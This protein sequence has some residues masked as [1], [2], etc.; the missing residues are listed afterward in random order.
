MSIRPESFLQIGLLRAWWDQN[1]NGIHNQ[2]NIFQ[3]F[4]DGFVLMGKISLQLIDNNGS[5]IPVDLR[6]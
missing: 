6:D 2:E 1:A 4:W 5:D 3:G